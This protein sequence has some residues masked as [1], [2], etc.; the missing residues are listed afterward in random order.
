MLGFRLA[1]SII[2]P[3]AISKFYEVGSLDMGVEMMIS[4]VSLA[5]ILNHVGRMWP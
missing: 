1:L 3:L 5:A 2:E 4:R